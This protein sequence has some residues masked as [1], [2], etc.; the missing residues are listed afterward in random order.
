MSGSTPPHAMFVASIC[1]E[2]SIPHANSLKEKRRALNSIIEKARARFG[3]S[4][5]EV[6]DQELWQRSV[7]GMALVTGQEHFAR[8]QAERV[9]A[10][11]HSH[12]EGEVCRAD[13]E[14]L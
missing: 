8:E 2:L 7:V 1:F 5:A 9:V 3:V 4:A 11:V 13:V 14:I 6:G 12:F 10:F